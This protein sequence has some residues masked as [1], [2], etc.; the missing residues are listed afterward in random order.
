VPSS[1][2]LDPFSQFTQ[3]LTEGQEGG[4]HRQGRTLTEWPSSWSSDGTEG[5]RPAC[6]NELN[7]E[8]GREGA[9]EGGL[10]PVD[11]FG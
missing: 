4:Q 9:M 10:V 2:R 3:S 11:W 5:S 6:A 8:G 1:G 7:E